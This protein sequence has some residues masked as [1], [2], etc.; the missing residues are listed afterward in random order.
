[1]R[2]SSSLAI[3]LSIGILFTFQTASAQVPKLPKIPKPNQTKPQPTP[4]PSAQPAPANDAQI[5]R[6]PE[7]QPTTS[8]GKRVYNDLN[9][10]DKPLFVKDSLYIQAKTH[11]SYWKFPNQQ[12]YSSWVPIVAFKVFFNRSHDLH[13]TVEYF[14]PDGSSWF[15][16]KLTQSHFRDDVYGAAE[17]DGTDLLDSRHKSN[18][19][20]TE[21]LDKKSSA[22]VGTYGIKITNS[23]TGEVVLQGKFKVNKF[24][25]D[26][27]PQNKNKFEFFVEH[28]WLLPIGYVGFDQNIGFDGIRP[29][30]VSI[31]LKGKI[32]TNE[33]EAR[34][35]YKGQ[36]IATTANRAGFASE[37]E[38]RTTEYSM[39]SRDL[40]AW[41]LWRFEWK[42][43]VYQPGGSFD[44]N[45]YPDYFYADKNPGEYTVKVYRNGVQVR[46]MKFTVGADGRLVD[47][48]YAKPIFLTRYRVIIPVK[49]MGP[50]KWDASSW[51]TDAFYGNPLTG[52]SVP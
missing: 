48:G 10:T 52:F 18:V 36:Q 40:H 1:M 39:N 11:N 34:L 23:D 7:A 25:W 37:L 20:T 32:E 22:G 30:E 2:K 27:D 17:G 50:E 12:N 24:L 5:S 26:G 45:N 51:K 43:F 44:P 42:T 49:I 47:G 9:P 21:M 41:K 6:Q 28:D 33:L 31:W 13:Y 16:E 38:E 35:F 15:S 29:L 8:A 14:N 19:N 46:E 3:A 4:T